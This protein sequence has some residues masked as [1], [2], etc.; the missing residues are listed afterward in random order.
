MRIKLPHNCVQFFGT[1][2]LQSTRLLFPWDSPGKNTGVDCHALFQGIF[3]TQGSNLYFLQLL[4]C[5]WI[6][7][8]WATEEAQE[9]R[10]IFFKGWSCRKSPISWNLFTDLNNNSG[11]LFTRTLKYSRTLKE[12]NFWTSLVAQWLRICL[13]MQETK[14]WFL[15]QDCTC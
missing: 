3:P 6:L 8:C 7:Y 10:H 12:Q 5:W 15:V 11:L 9:R 4:H 1:Y 14:V 13:P 2:G